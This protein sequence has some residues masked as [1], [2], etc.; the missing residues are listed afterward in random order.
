MVEAGAAGAG[1][2]SFGPT[3]YAVGD[4]GMADVARAAKEVLGDRGG[5]V[6]PTR[7]RN[8]GAAVRAE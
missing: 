5:T 3:V 4:S 2:S 6:I 1:L 8:D 7:A